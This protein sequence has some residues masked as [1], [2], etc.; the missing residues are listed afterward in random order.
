MFTQ[1]F[2]GR[3]L[4]FDAQAADIHADLRIVRALAGRPL[5]TED[6][7]IAAIARVHAAIVVTR[8][9]DGF[10]GCGVT[11]VDPWQT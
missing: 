10:A 7:M 6:G 1:A 4:A 9:V 2:T 8:D 3:V 5:A 11:I